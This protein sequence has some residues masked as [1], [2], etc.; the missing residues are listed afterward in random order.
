MR[1]SEGL[2]SQQRRPGRLTLLRRA[3]NTPWSG[4]ASQLLARGDDKFLTVQQPLEGILLL[5]AESSLTDKHFGINADLRDS[6]S[7]SSS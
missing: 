1:M 6:W 3:V 4:P 7:L 2:S 5:A